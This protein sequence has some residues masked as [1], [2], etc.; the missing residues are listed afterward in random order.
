MTSS[1]ILSLSDLSL[2]ALLL[3]G[4]TLSLLLRARLQ[5]PPFSSGFGSS[6]LS[7][8][9]KWAEPE[10]LGLQ[11]VEESLAHH[12]FRFLGRSTYDVPGSLRRLT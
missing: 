2:K 7:N 6:C 12:F 9:L 11:S 8:F 10:V 1:G 4:E 5:C 3:T